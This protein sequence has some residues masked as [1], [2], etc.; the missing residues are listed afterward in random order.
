MGLGLVACAEEEAHAPKVGLI[1]LRC[2]ESDNPQVEGP[3]VEQL[4]VAVSGTDVTDVRGTING[5]P[6]TLVEAEGGEYV[7]QPA[8]DDVPML[9]PDALGVTVQARDSRGLE[10][11]TTESVTP[12][13]PA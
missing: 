13:A 5:R 11:E 9:C 8:E 10:G 6:I 12:G 2:G 7:W 4:S 3:V 1:S